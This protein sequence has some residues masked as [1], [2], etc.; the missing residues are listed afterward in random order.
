MELLQEMKKKS[1]SFMALS[2]RKPIHFPPVSII[3]HPLYLQYSLHVKTVLDRV[4][5][6]FGLAKIQL[7]L[8]EPG[9]RP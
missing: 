9:N 2:V 6:W 4:G 3:L 1:I 8:A 5:D 7:P